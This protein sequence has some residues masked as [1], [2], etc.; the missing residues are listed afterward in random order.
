MGVYLAAP[1]RSERLSVAP[2]P[3]RSLQWQWNGIRVAVAWLA[4]LL[5]GAK[6][7]GEEDEWVFVGRD[8]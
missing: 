8:V 5:H 2:Q 3:R 7:A 6:R 1:A 4:R